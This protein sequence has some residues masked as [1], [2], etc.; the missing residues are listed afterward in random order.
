METEIN[1]SQKAPKKKFPF[2]TIVVS[3]VLLGALAGVYF[4]QQSIVKGLNEDKSKLNSEKSSLNQEIDKLKEIEIALN[5]RIAFLDKSLRDATASSRV[6][7]GRLN[8]SVKSSQKYD[9]SSP[10]T[11]DG[12]VIELEAKN[13]TNQ[14]LFFSRYAMKLKDNQNRSYTR[15]VDPLVKNIT[16]LSDQAVQP[17]ETINGGVFFEGSP[18][19][20]GT[21]TFYYEDQSFTITLN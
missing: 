9:S 17:G 16:P 5:Q 10:D 1:L 19:T 8:I 18:I 21:Y 14:V 2:V 12:I 15:V 3:V 11:S 20:S 7:I 13:N 6:Q 4:W